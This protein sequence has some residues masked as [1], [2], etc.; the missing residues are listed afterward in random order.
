M[1]YKI[2]F[3]IRGAGLAWR[4]AL[5]AGLLVAVMA[6]P[7]YCA[8]ESDLSRPVAGGGPTRVQVGLFLADLHKVTGADQ[9]FNADVVVKADWLD[10]RLAGRWPG[11]HRVALADIW[12]PRLTLVNQRSV[13]QLFP[14]RAEV[15][16][17]GMV[18]WQLR[19]LGSFS[20]RMDLKEFPMDQQHFEVKVVSLGYARDEVAVVVNTEKPQPTR[21]TTLSVTDW[22]IG[23][24]TLEAAEFETA[25]GDRSFSGARLRWEGRRYV[26]Y[27]AIQTIIPLV[28][29][30][31]MGWSAFWVS[32]SVVPARMSV[33][34]TTM[35]T[36]ISY[37]FALGSSIPTLTYL[38]RFDYFMLA[39]TVLIFVILAVV[40]VEAYLV[41]REKSA[42][43]NR[44]DFWA[45]CVFPVIFGIVFV[46]AWWGNR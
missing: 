42:L 28:F 14:D 6:A 45:R 20:T 38:T 30:V 36:L 15:D 22:E 23:P 5:L 29:I 3:N 35:L 1:I 39:S 7:V 31:L 2:Q 9:T 10:P 46:Y 34:M 11:V 24:A 37:R 21:A 32:A 19:W 44:I 25:P 40:S 13:V 17:S 12:N 41:S 16:P 4:F 8:E 26:Q 18:H 43:C 27:Y 33:T